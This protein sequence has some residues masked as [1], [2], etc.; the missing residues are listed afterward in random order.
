MYHIFVGSTAKTINFWY[1][2]LFRSE[3]WCFC[4]RYLIFGGSDIWCLRGQISDASWVRHL[5][6]W[7]RSLMFVGLDT[8]F[9]WLRYLKLVGSGTTC[10]LGQVIRYL[11]VCWNNWMLLVHQCR[12][13][14]WVKTNL[15]WYLISDGSDI[16]C[17]LGQMLCSINCVM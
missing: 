3:I 8:L 7:V 4:I 11:M 13:I 16:W 10:L 1:W 15:K 9:H 5:I 17:L 6:Y 12:M 2:L 14:W